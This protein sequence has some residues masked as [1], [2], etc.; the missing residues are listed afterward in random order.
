MISIIRNINVNIFKK[1]KKNEKNISQRTVRG[2]RSF[3]KVS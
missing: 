3:K 1:K 2:I